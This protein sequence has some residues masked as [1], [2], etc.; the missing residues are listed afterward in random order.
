M[1]PYSKENS[2]QVQLANYSPAAGPVAVSTPAAPPVPVPVPPATP[3]TAAP[4]VVWPPP[5]APPVVPSPAT[6]VATPATPVAPV[7]NPTPAAPVV[8]PTPGVATQPAAASQSPA[9]IPSRV[10][11]PA[12]PPKFLR[13]GLF[14]E[15]VPGVTKQTLNGDSGDYDIFQAFVGGNLGF[16]VYPLDLCYTR[17]TKFCMNLAIHISGGAG[18]LFESKASYF[19]AFLGADAVFFFG[20]F[21]W[22]GLQVRLSLGY[23]RYL[24]YG[25]DAEN[26]PTSW[27]VKPDSLDQFAYAFGP[28]L[29]INLDRVVE[30]LSLYFGTELYRSSS[31]IFPVG[32][33]IRF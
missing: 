19:N 26:V 3:P 4:S 17:K 31:F 10:P 22:I 27:Q 28:S 33:K 8:S 14:F 29:V 7:V 25:G 13:F 16:A 15:A 1:S 24:T 23:I 11:P 5:A 30:G 12:S 9:K 2:P 18:Y 32:V 21:H 6:P 20:S